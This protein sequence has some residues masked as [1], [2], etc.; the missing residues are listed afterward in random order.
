MDYPHV[1]LIS[2]LGHPGKT[3][4]IYITLTPVASISDA[5]AILS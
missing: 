3:R 1:K 4:L 5:E 2:H